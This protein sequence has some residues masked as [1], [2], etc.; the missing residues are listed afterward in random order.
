MCACAGSPKSLLG[1]LVIRRNSPH[2][3]RLVLILLCFA[4]LHHDCNNPPRTALAIRRQTVRLTALALRCVP[5]RVVVS[6]CWISS[7]WIAVRLGQYANT[8]SLLDSQVSCDFSSD[9]HQWQGTCMT[10]TAEAHSTRTH[11]TSL[12]SQRVAVHHSAPTH[13]LT[14]AA[15]VSAL[16]GHMLGVSVY[17]T[18]WVQLANSHIRCSTSPLF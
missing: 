13:T 16:R 12:T 5:Y 2:F 14:T 17:R 6:Q 8:F 1:V 11:Q 7:T 3:L 4:L 10:R 9:Y 18:T 15:R